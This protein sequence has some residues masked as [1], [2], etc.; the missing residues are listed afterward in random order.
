M[1]ETKDLKKTY[2]GLHALQGIDL[3]VEK[4]DLFGFIGPNGAGKTT[5]IRILTT[6]LEPTSGDAFVAGHSVRGNKSAIRGLVGYMPDSFGVYRDMTVTEYLHFF[7]AAWS[8][9]KRS[10][11]FRGG[12]SIA[13]S[14]SSMRTGPVRP[15]LSSSSTASCF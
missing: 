6:L 7:A 8:C 14:S 9:A 15:A 5:T 10:S 13:L 2:G 4:G 1:I 11:S 3:T 12:L